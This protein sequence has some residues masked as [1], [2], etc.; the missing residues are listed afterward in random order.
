[1]LTQLSSSVFRFPFTRSISTRIEIP[2][3]IVE[4]IYKNS[5]EVATPNQQIPNSKQIDKQQKNFQQLYQENPDFKKFADNLFKA[6]RNPKVKSIAIAFER[7]TNLEEVEGN[8]YFQPTLIATSLLAGIGLVPFYTAENY[9][10]FA[11]VDKNS[12][13]AISGHQDSMFLDEDHKHL[14]LIPTLLLVNGYSQSNAK[15]WVKESVDIINEL[16]KKHPSSYGVL[17]K[18]N[19]IYRS[20]NVKEN[21]T[22]PPHRIIGDNDEINFVSN[23]IYIP[24]P[25]DL[26]RFNISKDEA[27]LSILRFREVVNSQENRHEF[28]I[29]N[30]GVQFLI[31]KNTEAVHGRGEVEESAEPR[32]LIGIPLK[33]PASGVSAPIDSSRVDKQEKSKTV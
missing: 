7:Q 31:V 1:M 29:N 27:N 26:E 9:P 21:G 23:F 3:Q 13:S 10:A 20:R 15:T 6:H 33:Q 8:P 16:K 32:L 17:K 12:K 22:R 19:F 30:Q 5:V 14:G 2:S 24:V 4:N 28:V 25:T 11:L 18:L